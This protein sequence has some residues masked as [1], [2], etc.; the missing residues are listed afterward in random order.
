MV[1]NLNIQCF[2]PDWPG[3]KQ[4]AEATA[5]IIRPYCPVTILPAGDDYFNAQWEKTQQQFTG[6]VLLYVMAD[7]WPP[8][9]FGRMF[10]EIKR[11]MARGD[12]GWYAPD[13]AWT[14]YI[15]DKSKLKQVE[16]EIYEVPNTDSL[17]FAIRADVMRAMPFINPKLSFMWGMDLTAIATARRMGLKVVRDY[18]FKAKHPNHTGYGIADAGQGMI[19]LFNT[20]SPQLRADIAVLENEVRA[21]RKPFWQK[22]RVA[23]TGGAGFLGQHVVTALQSREADVWVARAERFDLRRREAVDRMYSEFQPNIVIHL[24]G[25]V[26]GLGANIKTPGSFFYDNL[27][28]GVNLL[29][30]ARE[31][32]IEKF[33]QMGSACEYPKDAPSPLRE[34]TV[35][36]GYPEP[37][38]AAYGIAKRALLTMGQAYRQQ[39]GLN[40]CHILSTNLYGPGDNFNLETSH[41]IPALIAKCFAAKKAGVHQVGVWG[42]GAATRDFIYVKDAAEGIV[43]ASQ[44]H[45]NP[46]PINLGSGTEV[47]IHLLAE[48]ISRHTGFNGTFAFDTGK[49]EGQS[50]RLLDVTQLRTFGFEARTSLDQGLKETVEWYLQNGQ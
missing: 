10:E 36:D 50:R 4:H 3:T 20:Y 32:G 29:D 1:T 39:Y 45:S 15:Y 6:D 34:S 42:T 43:V 40:V 13:I 27:V 41:V 28:M 26:G 5:A 7:V 33:V 17:C 25:A 16:P 24:A 22:K 31:H 37:T 19:P 18:R 30:G 21:L 12:V 38:N 48:K 49:P 35:W 47:P 23:V 2:I 8:E 44:L 14:S 9:E 46:A 11:V